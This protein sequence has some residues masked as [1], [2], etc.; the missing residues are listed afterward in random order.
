MRSKDH[1][2]HLIQSL[3]K[4]EKRYFTLEAR[5]SGRK[6][7]RYWELFQLINDMDTYDEAVVKAQFGAKVGD[8]KARLYEA[9][10]GALRDY[11][12]KK[13]YKTRIKELLTDAKILVER[14][15]YEQAEN[16]LDE[17][18]AL[19]IEIQDHLAV[20]EVNLHQRQ[21][22]KAYQHKDYA[23]QVEALVAEKDQ[24]L[25]IVET[26]FWLNDHYDRLSVEY[27]K[28]H[29]QLNAEQVQELHRNYAE[30]L[31]YQPQGDTFFTIWR[32]HQ[33]KA[34]YYRLS[35]KEEQEFQEFEHSV[36]LWPG[37]PKIW[38]EYYLLFLGDKFNLLSMASRSEEKFH[39]LPQLL[40]DLEQ[41]QATASHSQVQ[42]LLFERISIYRLVYLLNTKNLT[43]DA[44]LERIEQ[45]LAK[46]HIAPSSK[47]TI[48]LNAVLLLFLS[49]RFETCTV[50]LDKLW[51]LQRSSRQ[52]R[53]DIQHVSRIVFLLTVFKQGEY[54]EIENAQR[55]VKRYFQGLDVKPEKFLDFHHLVSDAIAKV[56][57][58]LTLKEERQHWTSLQSAIQAF[59]TSLPGG[60]N[61]ITLLW[62]DSILQ[63]KPISALRQLGK[64]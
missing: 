40:A 34:L 33:L 43:F 10:L 20:L 6:D 1:L 38:E 36:A 64:G 44:E 2:F 14:K 26:E 18:K 31:A 63:D 17:A 19:A 21:L 23:E 9:V 8:D 13:S 3:S 48:L 37:F 46:Y 24:H 25:K 47:L 28:F 59:G 53:Q 29:N 32:L 5:K 11:Q 42:N 51:K 41:E 62:I 57:V 56:Q 15:L 60:L 52:L 12:S 49:D 35:G 16:R 27:L 50:W 55:A 22:I 61:E 45:G 54:E 7:S 30:V 39:L 4:S 58:A